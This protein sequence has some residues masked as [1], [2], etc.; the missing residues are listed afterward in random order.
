V[1]QFCDV[2]IRRLGV[3]AD[4]IVVDNN[5]LGRGLAAVFED[6][7]MNNGDVSARDIC[8]A[9][10]LWNVNI[11]RDIADPVPYSPH[12]AHHASTA[13]L[14][15]DAQ[16]ISVTLLCRDNHYDILYVNSRLL[17]D[18]QTD[19]CDEYVVVNHADATTTGLLD[20]AY[21]ASSGFV[22]DG[23]MIVAKGGGQGA[24]LIA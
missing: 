24:S 15:K 22:D 1:K 23:V 14:A 7:S 3:P 18:E 2:Y 11:V 5:L 8:E 10:I 12:R 19:V 9:Q 16:S 6:E 17:Y 20:D 4:G 21:A 13:L